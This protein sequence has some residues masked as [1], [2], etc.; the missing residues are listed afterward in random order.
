MRST[1]TQPIYIK[2]LPSRLMLGLIVSVSIISCMILMYLPIT[3]AIKLSIILIVL[4][5]STYCILRDAMLFLPWSWQALEVD[6]KGQLK[7]LNQRG[8]E[9]QPALAA[10]SFVHAKLTILNFKSEQ[11]KWTLPPLILLT[12]TQN[13]NELRML[14]VWL[15]WNRHSIPSHGDS[16]ET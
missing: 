16:V 15:R 2:L 11:F 8:E 4:A 7:I 9:F 1:L 6:S 5:S 13:A 14:R 12:S 3:N 10:S